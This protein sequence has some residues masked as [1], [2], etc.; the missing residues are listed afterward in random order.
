M[1]TQTSVSAVLM[2]FLYNSILEMI[3][4]LCAAF[5]LIAVDLYFGI[6]AAKH[7][8]E[9]VRLSRAIRRSVGKAMEY[10]CWVMV[11]ATLS[12]CFSMRAVEYV[13]LGIVMGNEI[14]SILT[15][16]FELHGKKI[17]GL[18]IFT[19]VGNKAG[20]DVSNVKIEEIK[21]EKEG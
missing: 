14:I 9:E 19:I 15:N 3:P 2:A 10:I 17:H 21:K 1:V 11:S 5:V 7:R 20:I 16:W 13:I 6:A 4:Y 18:N 12:M 8:G